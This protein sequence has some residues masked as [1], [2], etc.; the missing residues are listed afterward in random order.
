MRRIGRLLLFFALFLLL[1]VLCVTG[2]MWWQGQQA[3][4]AP[5]GG[6]AGAPAAPAAQPAVPTVDVVVAGQP[7]RRGQRITEDMLQTVPFP[8]DRVLESY[9]LDPQEAVGKIALRDLPQGILITQGDLVESAADL[10]GKAG[11][12]L[13]A[14]I[15]PGYVAITIPIS[16]LT[17]VAYAIQPG[18]QVGIL[19]TLAFV[20][21]DEEFQTILPNLSGNVVSNAVVIGGE[22]GS[23]NLVTGEGVVTNVQ[24]TVGGA[25]SPVG[26]LEQTEDFTF[27]VLPSERQRPRF[28]TQM[29]IPS[30]WV[31]F[32]GDAPVAGQIGAGG[33]AATPAEE[34][35]PPPE[36]TGQPANQQQGQVP[37]PRP[38]VATLM[39]K[40]QDAVTIKYLL[41]RKVILTLVLRGPD[42]Q[43]DITTDAV[44]LRYLLDNYNLVIPAKVPY[45]LAPRVDEVQWPEKQYY[46]SLNPSEIPPQ[47]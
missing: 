17:S 29:I 42:D 6:E 25:N 2:F 24:Q 26:R 13:S 44:T 4:K 1:G 5:A 40:P 8:A 12:M 19:A 9:I 31:L 21:I 41:D 20:D 47:P 10:L 35:A 3:P 43:A 38:Q 36:Q 18:D 34:A 46:P 23:A 15:P 11:S 7:I 22:G 32:V 45:D 37:P 30:A 14:Q 27:Y 33:E 39:V 16:R 28:V